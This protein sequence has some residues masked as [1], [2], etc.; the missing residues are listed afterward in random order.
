[1]NGTFIELQHVCF[2]ACQRHNIQFNTNSGSNPGSAPEGMFHWG[3]A[4]NYWGFHSCVL[5]VGIFPGKG[6]NIRVKKCFIWVLST[7]SGH[8][9]WFSTV[10]VCEEENS[11]SILN[12]S[13]SLKLALLSVSQEL[14]SVRW[15]WYPC[16]GELWFVKFSSGRH[17]GRHTLPSCLFLSSPGRLT[18]V[19]G[20]T[21]WRAGALVPSSDAVGNWDIVQ[22]V[23]VLP[24]V[25][26]LTLPGE[27]HL[28]QL[29]YITWLNFGCFNVPLTSCIQ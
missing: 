25:V 20:V 14:L 26:T 18:R 7:L 8:I 24:A 29:F 1:M 17:S 12:S 10:E 21:V 28:S 23:T 3:Q 16:C 15:G 6:P 9:L 19:V 11:E 5:P 27:I 4:S 22:E 2:S 13:E